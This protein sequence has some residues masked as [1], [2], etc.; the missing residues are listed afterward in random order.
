MDYE[1]GERKGAVRLGVRGE[2]KEDRVTV[3]KGRVK[4]TKGGA[5]KGAVK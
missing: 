1:R 4:W 5:R 2:T 3:A